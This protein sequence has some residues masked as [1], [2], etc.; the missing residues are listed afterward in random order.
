MPHNHVTFSTEILKGWSPW[1]RLGNN[2]AI[3]W[4]SR[5][6]RVTKELHD[7]RFFVAV[8]DERT[9]KMVRAATP[10]FLAL[11]VINLA[12]LVFAVDSVPAIFA[13]TTDTFIVYGMGPVLFK[14]TLTVAPQ[15]FRTTRDGA[16]AY[17]VG[18]DR[19]YPNDGGFALKHWRRFQIDNAGI[20]VT[21]N[22]AISMGNVTLWDDKGN[23]TKVDKTWGYV[24]GG[25]GK[26]RIVLHHSSLPYPC[27][28]ARAMA[29][30]G[31]TT[32]SAALRPS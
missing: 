18:G 29:V 9:G 15:T 20:V 4:I 10:L 2:F 23:M 28:V 26:L 22:S 16:L 11:V 19:A 17:F 25:D 30:P 31:A 13:I 21:G 7:Q 32:K 3:K 6:M 5:H 14:P 12:D 1:N 8:P 27:L 24:R